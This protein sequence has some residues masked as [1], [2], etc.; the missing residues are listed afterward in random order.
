MVG[1]SLLDYRQLRHARAGRLRAC[2]ASGCWPCSA[3][4][5]RTVNGAHSWITLP[6][7]FQVEPSEFAKLALILMTAVIFGELRDGGPAARGC[8]TLVAA[9]ACGALP[10]VVLVVAEP[11]LGVLDPAA[12]DRWPA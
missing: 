1:V 2:R 4:W 9:L 3:R 5:A 10:L 7:G 6:G 11:A 12:A 8:G